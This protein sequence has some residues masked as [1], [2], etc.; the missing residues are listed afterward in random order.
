VVAVLL[1]TSN[2]KIKAW[3]DYFDMKMF[4]DKMKS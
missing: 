3:R 4:T 1:T 2:G